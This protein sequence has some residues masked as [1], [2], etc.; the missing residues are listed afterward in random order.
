MRPV[1]E[2]AFHVVIVTAAANKGIE[3]ELLCSHQVERLRGI[4][5]AA[6]LRILAQPAIDRTMLRLPALVVRIRIPIRTR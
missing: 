4:E 6:V 3:L 1:A 5:R 2:Y